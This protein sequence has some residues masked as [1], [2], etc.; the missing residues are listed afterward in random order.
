MCLNAVGMPTTNPTA[1]APLSPAYH[2]AATLP[3]PIFLSLARHKFKI[4]INT[5]TDTPL[6]NNINNKVKPVKDHE[7]SLTTPSERS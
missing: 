7:M 3:G 1:I 4:G 5:M 6:P 2:I